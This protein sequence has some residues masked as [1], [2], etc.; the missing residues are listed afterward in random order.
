MDFHPQ[1][2][3]AYLNPSCKMSCIRFITKGLKKNHHIPCKIQVT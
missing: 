1:Y 3:M 2:P